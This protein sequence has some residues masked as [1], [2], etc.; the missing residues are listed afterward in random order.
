MAE[1]VKKSTVRDDI[2]L[3]D[4]IY[5]ILRKVGGELKAPG[6]T[7]PALLESY[8]SLMNTYLDIAVSE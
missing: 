6:T 8:D 4:D 5:E 3:V 2:A 7:N 1:V